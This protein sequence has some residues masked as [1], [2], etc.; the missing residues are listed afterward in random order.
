[1]GKTAESVGESCLCYGL[2]A[3]TPLR[4]CTGV[5]IRG[6]LRE[7]YG[8][9]GSF[10]MDIACHCCCGCCAGIQ[11]AAEVKSRGD[12]PPGTMCMARE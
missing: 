6:K 10:P 3:L 9:E 11:E 1:M 2:L 7:K 4:L 5:I 8:I 12:A